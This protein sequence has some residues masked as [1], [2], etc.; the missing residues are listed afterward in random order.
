MIERITGLGQLVEQADGQVHVT[1]LGAL[2]CP[3]DCGLRL[4]LSALVRIGHAKTA[5]LIKTV[6]IS[7]AVK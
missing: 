7:I 6:S 3:E 2:R 4:H 5:H 1:A